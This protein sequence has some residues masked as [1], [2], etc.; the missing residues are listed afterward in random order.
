[1]IVNGFEVKEL[2]D[3]YVDCLSWRGSVMATLSSIEEAIEWAQSEVAPQYDGVAAVDHQ[4]IDKG[5]AQ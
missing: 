4:N 2:P 3:G 1:M 5:A